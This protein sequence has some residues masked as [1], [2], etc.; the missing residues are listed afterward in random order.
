MFGYNKTNITV[1][2]SSIRT[3]IKEDTMLTCAAAITYNL[4]EVNNGSEFRFMKGILEGELNK[5]ITY[6]VELTDDNKLYTSVNGLTR[7]LN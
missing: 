4:P 7:K 3:R 1:D 2:L 5:N 6:T